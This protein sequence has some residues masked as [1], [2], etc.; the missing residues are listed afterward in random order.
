[1]AVNKLTVSQHWNQIEDEIEK[2]RELYL[3]QYFSD[4]EKPEYIYKLW[5]LG[6]IS[7]LLV[8]GFSLGQINNWRPPMPK[9]LTKVELQKLID[10][11]NKFIPDESWIL[12][13]YKEFY[14]S[15]GSATGCYR[16]I[17]VT[18]DRN[19]SFK[20]DDLLDKQRGMIEKYGPK[21]GCSPCQRCRKQVLTETLLQRTIIGRS[22][23]NRGEAIITNESMAFCSEECAAHEQW[24][25]EG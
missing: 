16:L 17:E 7:N 20:K 1:M 25:R 15:G 24:S 5:G 23:N 22:R 8:T 11:K 9:R 12:V 2:V 14:E 18:P 19:L 21:E 4:H 10:W 13:G 6:S 3:E